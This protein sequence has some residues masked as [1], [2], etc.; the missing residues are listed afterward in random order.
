[1]KRKSK[2]L[3]TAAALGVVAAATVVAPAF[4]ESGVRICG[5]FYFDNTRAGGSSGPQD[6][7]SGA[8]IGKVNKGDTAAC[9]AVLDQAHAKNPQDLSNDKT[10]QWI[11]GDDLTPSEDTP[12][13]ELISTFGNPDPCPGMQLSTSSDVHLVTFFQHSVS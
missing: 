7:F 9:Q 12:C 6:N 3:V 2:Y 4:A 13:E 11:K 5:Q 1:M 10:I 8:F